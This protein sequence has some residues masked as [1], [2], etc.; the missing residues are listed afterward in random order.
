VRCTGCGYAGTR[1][2]DVRKL[3]IEGPAG[4]IEAAMR[5]ASPARAAAVLAHPHPLQGGSLHNPVVFHSE[6]ELNRAGLTTLRFNFRGVGTSDG[7]HDEGRGEVDDVAAALSWTRGIV[8][9]DPLIL[10]GYSFGAWCGIRHAVT[11]PKVSALIAIGLPVT[12][13][14]PLPELEQLRCPLVVVQGSED[15][16]GPPGEL[17]A[18][19]ERCKPDAELRLVEGTSH[20]F[21][22]RARDAAAQVKTAAE[23]LLESF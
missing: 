5:S 15:E 7:D 19:L 1:M 16:F 14:F 12:T 9:H 21:P 23:D 17:R 2:G 10:V 20:L 8:P 11:N 22:D 4:R 6:R 3:W 18:L 13:R